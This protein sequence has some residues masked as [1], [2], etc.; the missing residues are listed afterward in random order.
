M[1]TQGT[2]ASCHRTTRATKPAVQTA[3]FQPYKSCWRKRSKSFDHIHSNPE[4]NNSADN[5]RFQ[6]S[7]AEKPALQTAHV[8]ILIPHKPLQ[9]IESKR[10]TSETRA[11]YLRRASRQMCAATK[12][13]N[14]SSDQ[15]KCPQDQKATRLSTHLRDPLGRHKAG[16]LNHG[17][18]RCRQLLDEL[19][20]DSC[21]HVRLLV[22]EAIARAHFDNLNVLG[23][24]LEK[25]RE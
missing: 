20:L 19:D 15:I 14:K 4:D 13:Q 8:T 3:H 5:T 1:T 11:A 9:R 25:L 2:T 10:R 17:E 12:P 24:V 16:R 21:W 22:L 23:H 7:T 6:E 18:P